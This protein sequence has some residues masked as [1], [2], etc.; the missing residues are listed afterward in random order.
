MNISQTSN[1]T[2]IAAVGTWHLVQ[3]FFSV[4]PQYRHPE[5]GPV[6]INLFAESYGGRYGPMFAEYFEE[7]N[8][9]RANGQLDR[10]ETFDMNLQSL[11][12]VNGC[13]DLDT[14]TPHYLEYANNNTYGLQTVSE[15]D[16][17]YYMDLYHAEGGCHDLL[18]QCYKDQDQ[19][20]PNESG[21]SDNVNKKC[22]EAL[23]VCLSITSPYYRAGRSPYDISAPAADP[24]PSMLFQEYLNSANIQSTIGTPVNFTMSNPAVYQAFLQTGDRARD[25]N[26]PR[27]ASLLKRGVRIGLM[28]G[29]RDFICNWFGGQ[30]VSLHLAEA[31]GGAYK[32]GYPA[33]GY[34]D[35]IINDSY[36]GGAVRQFANLSFSRIYQ[37]GHAVAAYQPETAFQIFARIIAG[38]SVATGEKVDLEQFNTTGPANTTHSEALPNPPAPTCYLRAFR[39]TCDDAAQSLLQDGRGVVINGALYSS[40]GDWHLATPTATESLTMTGVYT[41]TATPETSSGDEEDSATMVPAPSTWY[42]VLLALAGYIIV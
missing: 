40:S 34:A 12:L 42:L 14:E 6:N 7:Q 18:R 23:N 29:D 8:T 1:T 16:Y 41:A 28:Y 22:Q 4:F 9:R 19:L 2:E 30:A 35:I 17:A 15:S 38:T 32:D 37:A 13:V 39:D 26:I 3:A 21:D 24:F 27:L 25:G 20:D 10:N 31:A 36:V 11:G 5:N 33:A